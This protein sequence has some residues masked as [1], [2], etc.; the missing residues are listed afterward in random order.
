MIQQY[1]YYGG[2]GFLIKYPMVHRATRAVIGKTAPYFKANSW[3][4]AINEFKEISLTDY[5][6]KW[7]LLFFYPLDFTFV[8]PT[9]IV[10]FSNYAEA[11]RK[12]N[13][14]VLGCSV[15]SHFTHRRWTMEPKNVGGLGPINI[16]LL[17]DLKTEV[18]SAY[19]VMN[20]DG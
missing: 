2:F 8:C 3:I 16:P 7:L 20:D 15:D 4:S 19:G 9:E 14:E 13:C 1:L 5:K 18:G 11:F 10:E 17:A 6:S 12:H